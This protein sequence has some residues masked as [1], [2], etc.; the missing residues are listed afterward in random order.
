VTAAVA[1]AVAVA[2]V[3][4]SEKRSGGSFDLEEAWLSL[5]KARRRAAARYE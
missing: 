5:K 1:V 3:V 2:A 4:E